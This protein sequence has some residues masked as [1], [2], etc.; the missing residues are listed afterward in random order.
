[1][2]ETTNKARATRMVSRWAHDAHERYGGEVGWVDVQ[3]DIV[4]ALEAA[5]QRGERRVREEKCEKA[6][7]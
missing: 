6:D 3:R 5:E 2:E 1:M 4:A 7:V